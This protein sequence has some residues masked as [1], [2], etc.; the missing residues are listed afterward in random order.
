MTIM[1]IILKF[2]LLLGCIFCSASMGECL[3]KSIFDFGA[4]W[5]VGAMVCGCLAIYS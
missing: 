1:V 4:I 5:F 3:C 2:I